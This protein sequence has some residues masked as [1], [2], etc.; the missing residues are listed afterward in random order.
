VQTPRNQIDEEGE[1][2]TT[3]QPSAQSELFD[4]AELPGRPMLH[5]HGKRPLRE[6]PYYPAQLRERYG[7]TA[8]TTGGEDDLPDGWANHLYWGDN[9]QVM[10][11][12]MREFRGKI[13]LI[14][15]DPSHDGEVFHPCITDVSARRDELVRGEYTSKVG[16]YGEG[17]LAV[18][19]L[20]VLDEE[21][22]GVIDVVRWNNEQ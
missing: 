9:L 2:G 13:K 4:V 6:I 10:A 8:F 12:L 20:D 22:F 3:S 14:C 11:H 18:K 15:I 1:T 7:S 17:G 5:W 16:E 21:W 19:I